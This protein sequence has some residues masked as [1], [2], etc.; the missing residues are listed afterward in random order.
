MDEHFAVLK[1][2][3]KNAF[4]LVSSQELLSKCMTFPGLAPL[5]VW[6]IAHIHY[7]FTPLGHLTSVIRVQQVYPLGPLFLDLLLHKILSAIGAED[8][9]IGFYISSMVP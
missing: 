6:C 3:M 7:C 1:I 2:D 8:D 5:A 9:S 4:N